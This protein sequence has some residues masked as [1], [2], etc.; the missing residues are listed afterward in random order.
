MGDTTVRIC[1]HPPVID[2][3]ILLAVHSCSTLTSIGV[4][5]QTNTSIKVKPLVYLPVITKNEGELAVMGVIIGTTIGIQTGGRLQQ[6]I[7][8][9][10]V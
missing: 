9:F 1:S 2:T 8:I 7:R 10:Y 3:R 4:V 6:T 5:L